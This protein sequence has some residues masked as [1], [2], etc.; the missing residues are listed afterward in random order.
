MIRRMFLASLVAASMS[1][2]AQT[3]DPGTIT[4][5]N[6]PEQQAL[7][8][9]AVPLTVATEGEVKLAVDTQWF[10]FDRDRNG[11]LDQTEF[12]AML[13]K[14]RKAAAAPLKDGEADEARADTAAF[15]VADVDKNGAVNRDEFVALLKSP[16]A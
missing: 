3:A 10:K 4:V 7:A 12:G 14:F 16:A 15:A 9:R 6:T 13:H 1:A 11:G 5:E 8:D 2:L